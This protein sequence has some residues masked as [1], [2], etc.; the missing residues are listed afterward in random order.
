MSEPRPALIELLVA[1]RD[2]HLRRL[3]AMN[4]RIAFLAVAL[5]VTVLLGAIHGIDALS[6][7]DLGGDVSWLLLTGA[8]TFCASAAAFALAAIH[9]TAD[10]SA[11]ASHLEVAIARLIAGDESALVLDDLGNALA[12]LLHPSKRAQ[13]GRYLSTELDGRRLGLTIYQKLFLGCALLLVASLATSFGVIAGYVPE[14]AEDADGDVAIQE[15][16]GAG[17]PAPVSLERERH[18]LAHGLQASKVE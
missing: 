16:L 6:D 13:P 12:P 1:A 17:A 4:T 10:R 7:L 15:N 2:E 3:H 18:A 14:P 9:H 11:A 8:C 5:A